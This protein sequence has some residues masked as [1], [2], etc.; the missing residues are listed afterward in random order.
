MHL[1]VCFNVPVLHCQ[2]PGSIFAFS[3]ALGLK[4]VL[5][6]SVGPDVR[7]CSSSQASKKAP[8]QELTSVTESNFGA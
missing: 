5:L 3:A 2:K 6:S 1:N 8:L 4:R 7:F